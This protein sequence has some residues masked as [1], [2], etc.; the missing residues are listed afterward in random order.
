MLSHQ[1][2]TQTDIA[3]TARLVADQPHP[4]TGYHLARAGQ[5]GESLRPTLDASGDCRILFGASS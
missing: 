5:V 4:L 1:E 3:D 2:P